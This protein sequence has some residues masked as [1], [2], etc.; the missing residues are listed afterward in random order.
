MVCP[1][2]YGSI[3][4]IE[5]ISY[6]RSQQFCS[7]ITLEDYMI[8]SHSSDMT[9]WDEFSERCQSGRSS[10]ALIDLDRCLFMEEC[11]YETSLRV[12]VPRSCSPKNHLLVGSLNSVRAPSCTP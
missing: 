7:K 1:C 2:C 3:N 12:M 8:L 4:S 6:P 11:G 5:S 9:T 10:M